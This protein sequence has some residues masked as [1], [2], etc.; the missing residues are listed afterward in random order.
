MIPHNLP[1]AAR[2]ELLATNYTDAVGVTG[3][4]ITTSSTAPTSGAAGWSASAPAT[5][6]V[7]ADGIYILYPWAKDAAGN[8]SATYGRQLLL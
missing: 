7:V 2:Q 5:Y 8:V 6:A 1:L 3:Y 4:M